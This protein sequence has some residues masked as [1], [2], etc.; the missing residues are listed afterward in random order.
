MKRNILFI[1]TVLITILFAACNEEEGVEYTNNPTEVNL[2]TD[3]INAIPGQQI[4]IEAQLT[5]DFGIKYVDLLSG[6]LSLN[7]RIGISSEDEIISSI[8]FSY[9]HKIPDDVTGNEY[10]IAIKV[11]NLTGQITDTIIKVLLN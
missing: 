4:T 3:V 9:T 11:K 1:I 8:Q 10:E 6:G 5:D 2:S 7:K